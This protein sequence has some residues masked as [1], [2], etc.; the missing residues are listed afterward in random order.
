MARLRR[1]LADKEHIGV[2]GD[3]DADGITGTALLIKALRDLGASVAAY[4]PDRVDEGHGLNADAVKYLHERGISLLITVDCGATSISEVD[5]ASDLGIDTIITDHHSVLPTLPKSHAL[6]NPRH[7]DSIYP[8]G[9]LTGVGMSFKLIEALYE[10]MGLPRPEHLLEFVALGH[11]G[12]MSARSRAKIASWSS[13]AWSISI[14]PKTPAYARWRQT[15][16]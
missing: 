13:A 15:P 4:I 14:A 1:A 12:R 9:D 2:Y 5:L 16:A 3:F 8:F 7:P 10:D 6:I 11:R